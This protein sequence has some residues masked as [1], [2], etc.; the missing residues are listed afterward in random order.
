MLILHKFDDYTV[1]IGS[2]G[3]KYIYNVVPNEQ[4][5]PTGGYTDLNWICRVKGICEPHILML[6]RK[7]NEIIKN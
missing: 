6:K 2:S 3:D 4:P 5:K 7:A 1:Y